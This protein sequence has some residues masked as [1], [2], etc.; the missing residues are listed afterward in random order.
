[1]RGLGVISTDKGEVEKRSL[2][3]YDGD[4]VIFNVTL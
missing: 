2:P 1:V 4:V 3:I